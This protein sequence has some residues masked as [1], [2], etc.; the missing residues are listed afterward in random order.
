VQRRSEKEKADVAK[1]GIS[2]FAKDVLVIRDS[3]QMALEN[4]R[5]KSG[6]VLDGEI[7]EFLESAVSQLYVGANGA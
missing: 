4:C 2:K 6:A 1:Y 3:L 5:N 7:D